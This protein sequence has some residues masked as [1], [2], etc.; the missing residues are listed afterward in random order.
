MTK[1]LCA[2]SSS[3]ANLTADIADHLGGYHR[4]YLSD[5]IHLEFVSDNLC[6][7]L[8]YSKKELSTLVGHVYTVLVHPDDTGI[9]DNFAY[10]LS[11]QESCE[12]VSYRLIKR[13]GSTVRVID[14]MTSVRG[15]DGILRGYS[16][17]CETLDTQSK[18]TV[19]E[20]FAL[21]KVFSGADPLVKM[22]CGVAQEL[23][24]VDDPWQ[25]MLLMDFIAMQDRHKVED[26]FE[27][28]YTNE[29]SGMIACTLV[30]TKGTPINCNIWVERTNAGTCLDDAGFCVKLEISSASHQEDEQAA[31]FSKKLF[32]S[33]SEDVFEIDRADGTTKYI[34]RSGKRAIN[35]PLNVRM[36]SQDF[37][38]WYLEQVPAHSK[39][40]VTKFLTQAMLP[41][42]VCA[43]AA[44]IK[45]HF[46]MFD[47][48]GQ[49]EPATLMLIPLSSKKCFL[50][51][52]AESSLT[53]S[54]LCAVANTANKNI[55]VKLFGTFGIKIDGKAVHI[56]SDKGRELL[57]LMVQK[58]GAFLTT[59][60][61]ITTLWE[62]EPDE[63]TRARYRKVA[64]RLM[65]ELKREGIDY[66]VENDR[67]ARRVVP[68]FFSCDY[69]DYQDGFAE[70]TDEL[71]PEYYWS[72]YLRV[73]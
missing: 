32:T 72:E 3:T 20:Q 1:E 10:G 31:A 62:C 59:R 44:P 16:V 54:G 34:C 58:R 68:E 50:S 33:F 30:S 57:A 45:A 29:Y 43:S 55:E 8:G 28:A 66:I 47:R 21:L 2:I 73:S 14:T 5:P 26:A 13:G 49:I 37:K 67:G 61:A 12:S 25:Q 69:Y 41:N 51:L 15:D 42:V 19:P 4:C 40:I 65:I 6:S 36:L 38:A 11:Q 17:V 60:E 48:N 71:L 53:G 7:M 23:L 64:S 27:R 56:R 18:G 63:T 39:D 22:F 35:I 24:S 46:D 70:P 9:F 52:N